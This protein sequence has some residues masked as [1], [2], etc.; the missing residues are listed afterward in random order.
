MA[1]RR[2]SG[3]ALDLQTLQAVA[4]LFGA[5]APAPAQKV[6]SEREK[7]TERTAA[8][9]SVH[10]IG[11]LMQAIESDADVP[12]SVD[13][14]DPGRRASRVVILNDVD[15][16]KFR[17]RY[18]VVREITGRQAPKPTAEQEEIARLKAELAAAKGEAAPE[19]V[20]A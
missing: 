8:V 11:L 10:E 19:T 5:S 16:A 3:I 17:G 4:G 20:D 1:G 13:E 15:A 18:Q 12:Y 14:N 6:K 7:P 9:L 2:N